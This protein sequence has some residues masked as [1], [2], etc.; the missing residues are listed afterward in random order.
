MIYLEYINSKLNTHTF[1]F[2]LG[3]IF[4]LFFRLLFFIEDGGHVNVSNNLRHLS[5]N[6][7][8]ETVYMKQEMYYKNCDVFV[9]N[10]IQKNMY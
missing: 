3:F 8:I 7:Q 6:F 4:C 2:V 1:N 5:F 10:L 9:T